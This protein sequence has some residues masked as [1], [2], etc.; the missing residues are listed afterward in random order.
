MFH[1][2]ICCY[3][4]NQIISVIINGYLVKWLR[5]PHAERQDPSSKP[6]GTK[7]YFQSKLISS[8]KNSLEKGEHDENDEHDNDNDDES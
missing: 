7:I 3:S 8:F 4:T 6:A 2:E 5:R 1:A